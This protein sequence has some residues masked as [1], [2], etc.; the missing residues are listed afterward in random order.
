M[1]LI[2]GICVKFLVQDKIDMPWTPES[3]LQKVVVRT[4]IY[5]VETR[6]LEWDRIQSRYN[7]YLAAGVP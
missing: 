5:M 3:I 7:S 2:L 1:L 6:Q 4:R